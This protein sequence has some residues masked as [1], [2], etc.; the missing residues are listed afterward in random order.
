MEGIKNDTKY[1]V[2]L[3]QLHKAMRDEPDKH[4]YYTYRNELIYYKQCI[5]I[6]STSTI[7]Y[8]I[9]I[10]LHKSLVKRHGGIEQTLVRTST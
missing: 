10:E 9:L 3:L 4:M 5:V 7:R 6:T 2:E 8:Q 1:N